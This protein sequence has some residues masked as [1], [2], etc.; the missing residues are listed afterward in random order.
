MKRTLI[1]GC[2]IGAVLIT[3]IVHGIWTGRL[4]ITEEP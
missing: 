1:T 2:A 4:E 3:G